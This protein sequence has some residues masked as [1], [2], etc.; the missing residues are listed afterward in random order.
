MSVKNLQYQKFENVNL[1][2]NDKKNPDK[3]NYIQC[4]KNNWCHLIHWITD[5]IRKYFWISYQVT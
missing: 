5:K 1:L 3:S 2:M 4:P